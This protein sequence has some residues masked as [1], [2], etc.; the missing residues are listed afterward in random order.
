MSLD[1]A[2]ENG[3]EKRKRY[4][5]SKY[6]DRSCR[7]NGGCPYCFNSRMHA[8]NTRLYSFRERLKEYGENECSD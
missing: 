2:I 6:A 7:C 4:Y 8:D 3:K 1:K 5:Q